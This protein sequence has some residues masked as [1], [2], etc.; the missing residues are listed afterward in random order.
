MGVYNHRVDYQRKESRKNKKK[1]HFINQLH[2]IQHNIKE[3]K[4]DYQV[5]RYQPADLIVFKYKKPEIQE[6]KV[7]TVSEAVKDRVDS[8]FPPRHYSS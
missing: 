5:E 3:K 7:L 4:E 8:V 2:R 1:L 6:E